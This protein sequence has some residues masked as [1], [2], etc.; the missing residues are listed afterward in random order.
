MRCF[1]TGC[2][3]L[4]R[5][6]RLAEIDFSGKELWNED[7]HQLSKDV[8]QR[9]QAE[10]AQWMYESF[11]TRVSLEFFFNRREVGEEISMCETDAFW[12][13]G[14]SRSEDDLDEVVRLNCDR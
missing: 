11:P 6:V 7:S 9:Q 4:R 5:L 1:L 2:N 14:R 12:F 10:K 3:D 13:G 8:A